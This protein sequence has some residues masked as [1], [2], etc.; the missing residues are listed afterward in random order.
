MLSVG[1]NILLI[2]VI[3]I[4]MVSN[5]QRR[6]YEVT[7][8]EAPKPSKAPKEHDLEITGADETHVVNMSN[9]SSDPEITFKGA[10]EKKKRS[11]VSSAV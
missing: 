10:K 8:K 3:L 5:C 1:L 4:Q 2:L 7:G 9:D 6:K 11:E